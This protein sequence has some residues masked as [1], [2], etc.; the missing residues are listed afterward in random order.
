M[1]IF[2]YCMKI[3]ALFGGALNLVITGSSHMSRTI[4]H[5]LAKGIR[6][7][8]L[9]ERSWHLNANSMAAVVSRETD[10]DSLSILVH[11]LLWKTSV[12][13]QQAYDTL[14][15]AVKL[16]GEGGWH[17]LGDVMFTPDTILREQVKLVS[18]PESVCKN[19]GK[20]FI[21]L[22]L[23]FVFGS[24]CTNTTHGS[25]TKSDT[26]KAHALNEHIRQRHTIIK[27]LNSSG[28]TNHKVIDIMHCLREGPDTEENR[29][30]CLKKVTHRNNVN[31]SVRMSGRVFV[32]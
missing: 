18:S 23:R 3:S 27:S 22:I 5:L 32:V 17:L 20:I 1:M 31:L 21:P 16:P 26:H 29:L 25:N 14:S 30:T 6:I 13:F 28:I 15:L 9:T 24:C 4:P 10:L 12:R 2:D 11:D 7:A 19:R 8:G